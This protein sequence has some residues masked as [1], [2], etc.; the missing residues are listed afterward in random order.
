MESQAAARAPA[1]SPP[2]AAAA[3]AATK[4]GQVAAARRAIEGATK[5]A[6]QAAT[7]K[8]A[9]A[10][11]EAEAVSVGL[12]AT[13]PGRTA[14]AE[15]A[16]AAATEAERAMAAA[17]RAAE[18]AAAAGS[19]EPAQELAALQQAQAQQQAHAQAQ[20][21]AQAQA[22]A[23]AAAARRAQAAQAAEA[24]AQ[25]SAAAS[26]V[27]PPAGAS[28]QSAASSA[29]SRPPQSS[30]ITRPPPS[31]ELS[32]NL[33]KGRR[34]IDTPHN[35]SI[36]DFQTETESE[37]ESETVLFKDAVKYIVEKNSTITKY[38]G[39]IN[40]DIG[41]KI[42]D[43]ESK[44]ENPPPAGV[45][46]YKDTNKKFCLIETN[47]QKWLLY[48]ASIM[49]LND[50]KQ[51]PLNRDT[52]YSRYNI[53]EWVVSEFDYYYNIIDDYQDIKNMF[54]ISDEYI[55]QIPPHRVNDNGTLHL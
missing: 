20:A 32:I 21:A 36:G 8:A 7:T 29:A 54:K 24:A 43:D 46:V 48:C 9:A 38:D 25:A 22:L 27:A 2:S 34:N 45:L 47:K 17:G 18:A 15:R 53:K 14:V 37:S 33:F 40:I 19:P 35:K 41:D 52:L 16:M 39:N 3:T 1:P 10:A 23:Q 30:I 5:A 55:Q 50:N 11:A 31:E 13:G 49:K 44:T 26:S 42:T 28:A 12:P 51:P 4:A 6:E